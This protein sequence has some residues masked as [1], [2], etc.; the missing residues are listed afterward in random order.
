[1]EVRSATFPTHSLP[2]P[3][4]QAANIR[5]LVTNGLW[6]ATFAFSCGRTIS[7]FWHRRAYAYDS[8]FGSVFDFAQIDAT[9]LPIK[10]CMIALIAQGAAAIVI[11][12]KCFV[13]RAVP[14]PEFCIPT[15]IDIVW[16]L[17]LSW[18]SIRAVK[19][20]KGNR[21][22]AISRSQLVR[23]HHAQV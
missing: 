12:G 2:V 23:L 18:P 11:A 17:L 1:M 16:Q 8:S 6:V 15:S 7:S 20:Q 13:A 4:F 9:T 3:T 5:L 22:G 21:P 19:Y 14:R 10:Q